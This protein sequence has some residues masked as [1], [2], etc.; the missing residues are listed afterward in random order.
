MKHFEYFNHW[1]DRILNSFP[2]LLD[3][4]KIKTIGIAWI[5]RENNHWNVTPCITGDAQYYNAV[6][7]IRFNLEVI[8]TIFFM[9]M[10]WHL[11]AWYAWSLL[12]IMLI[13]ATTLAGSPFALFM[14]IR[15]ADTGKR[16]FIQ[17]GIGWKQSG[18]IAVH[19]RIQSDASSAIGYHAGLPNT[20]HAV[21][22]NYGNH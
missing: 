14:M 18:R 5:F 7:F 8:I 21:A 6:F 17:T 9:L 2:F 12:L 10:T 4:S 19:C 11:L 13:F 22:W 1:Y 16:Q 20:D 3:D 15:W